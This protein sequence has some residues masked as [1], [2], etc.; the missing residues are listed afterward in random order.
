[1]TCLTDD[2]IGKIIECVKDSALFSVCHQGPFR[3]IYS[4]AQTFKKMFKYLDPKKVTLRT[5][6]N[7]KERLAYYIIYYLLLL[8]TYQ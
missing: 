7:M 2:A 6:K 1:M 4:R 3:T 5:D 8:I